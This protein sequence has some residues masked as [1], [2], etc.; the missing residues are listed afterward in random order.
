[1]PIEKFRSKEAYRKN[2]A[3]RHMHGIP[4][5][6]SKVVVGGKEHKVKHS[7]N[8]ERKAIDKRQRNKA[9]HDSAS[10][11]WRDHDGKSRKD[12]FAKR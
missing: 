7:A 9:N 3:Y 12:A 10:Y 1:M 4:F 5:T 6:A 2:L 11:N 8:P